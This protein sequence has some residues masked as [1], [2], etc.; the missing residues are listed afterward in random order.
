[1]LPKGKYRNTVNFPLPYV[2]LNDNVNYGTYAKGG[3]VSAIARITG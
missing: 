2:V 3:K 1:M